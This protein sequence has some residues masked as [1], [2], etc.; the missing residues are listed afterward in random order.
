MSISSPRTV[1]NGVEEA[2]LTVG[3]ETTLSFSVLLLFCR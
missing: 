1:W 2:V 3:C